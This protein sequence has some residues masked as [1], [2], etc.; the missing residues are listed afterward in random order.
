MNGQKALLNLSCTAPLLSSLILVGI[1]ITKKGAEAPLM[2][3][4]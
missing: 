4:L 3:K 2:F 1:L